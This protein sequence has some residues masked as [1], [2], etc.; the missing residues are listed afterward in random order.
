MKYKQLY[1]VIEEGYHYYVKF[2]K[3]DKLVYVIYKYF[4]KKLKRYY[5]DQ[6][7]IENFIV[8]FIEQRLLN[9]IE[10]YQKKFDNIKNNFSFTSYFIA[11][12]KKAFFSYRQRYL[13]LNKLEQINAYDVETINFILDSENRFKN[14]FKSYDNF[15]FIILDC[16]SQFTIM[17]RIVFKLFYDFKLN[18]EEL[19]YLII[20]FGFEKTKSFLTKYYQKKENINHINNSIEKNC[21]KFFIENLILKHQGDMDTQYKV[22]RYALYKKRKCLKTTPSA[23]I[24]GSYLNLK[25]YKIYNQLFRIRK[26]IIYILNSHKHFMNQISQCA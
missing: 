20:H 13:S 4:S 23:K 14:L 19:Q 5:Y 1:N 9:V 2:H 22:L 10:N 7:L 16:L 11:S 25:N 3:L 18:M 12:F 24:I 15:W 17:E 8:D 26:K 6:E 21:H